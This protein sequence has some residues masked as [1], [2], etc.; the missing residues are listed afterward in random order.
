MRNTTRARIEDRAYPVLSGPGPGATTALALAVVNLSFL[1]FPSAEMFLGLIVLAF[2]AAA[3]TAL[4]M[5]PSGRKSEFIAVA[6]LASI[7]FAWGYAVFFG[8]Q[9]FSAVLH[10]IVLSC[11]ALVFGFARFLRCYRYSY[12]TATA[13][14][15]ACDADTLANYAEFLL[16]DKP[17]P[18]SPQVARE[19]YRIASEEVLYYVEPAPR[20]VGLM[21]RYIDILQSGIGGHVDLQE[22]VWWIERVHELEDGMRSP[23]VRELATRSAK[24]GTRPGQLKGGDGR[25]RYRN[26]RPVWRVS[27]PNPAGRDTCDASIAF[28]AFLLPE[29]GLLACLLCLHD[30]DVSPT[31]RYRVFDVN[32]PEAEAFLMASEHRLSWRLEMVRDDGQKDLGGPDVARGEKPERSRRLDLAGTGLME[33]LETVFSHNRTLGSDFDGEAALALFTSALDS[34]AGEEGLIAAWAAMDVACL[35]QDD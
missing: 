12:S 14:A 11:A 27:V 26:G 13:A 32:D 19:F 30:D 20:H 3:G 22:A 18:A 25:L 35:R 2:L 33:S 24:S 7:A 15:D 6:L 8:F 28:Y 10:Y 17:G 9:T 4:R 5:R 1:L 16:D 31:A 21:K 23:G 29:G 34:R